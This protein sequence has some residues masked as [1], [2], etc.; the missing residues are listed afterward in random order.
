MADMRQL[1]NDHLA[2]AMEPKNSCDKMGTPIAPESCSAAAAQYFS[3]EDKLQSERVRMQQA[4]MRQWTSQQ[5]AERNARDTETK[6]ET[7]RFDQ[8][9][10]AVDQMRGQ[11]EDASA[12][13][14]AARRAWT[15]QQNEL[16]AAEQAAWNKQQ[17]EENE[18]LNKMEAETN[19]KS[20]FLNENTAAG[21]S[22]LADYRVRPDN[23]KGFN[24]EQTAWI[25]KDNER[26]HD[27]KIAK[28]NRE[29]QTEQEWADH[30]MNVSR[31]MEAA[32]QQD[33]EHRDYV[34]KLQS[35][36][37]M[38]QRVELK[39]KQEQMRKDKFGEINE[40]FFQGFGT[41]CR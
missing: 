21:I 30:Q 9:L 27:E 4:Q 33:K 7:L 10:T 14:A 8:Y 24:K 15:R 31:V 34:N 13:E 20:A 3:G 35:A 5:I 23:F 26:V 36:D 39:A 28:S 40:G 11:L 25:Y 32:E 37:L 29:K 41:S 12:Q 17:S 22:A 18:R 16:R 1:R 6:E 19:S 38:E 2:H